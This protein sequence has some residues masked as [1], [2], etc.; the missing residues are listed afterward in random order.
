MSSLYCKHVPPN[1]VSKKS[2]K[3]EEH[4]LVTN[5]LRLSFATSATSLASPTYVA[6]TILC[7]T[8]TWSLISAAKGLTTTTINGFSQLPGTSLYRCGQQAVAQQLPLPVKRHTNTSRT[9]HAR[10]KIGSFPLYR[11]KRLLVQ[12]LRSTCIARAT[13]TATGS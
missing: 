3:A 7:D 4:Q 10:Q 9:L 2:F 13:S 8:V 1:H 11:A 12:Q 5:F 6:P